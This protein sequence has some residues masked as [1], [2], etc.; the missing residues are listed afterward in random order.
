MR[1]RH[2]RRAE[3]VCFSLDFACFEPEKGENGMVPVKLQL[4]DVVVAGLMDFDQFV[5]FPVKNAEEVAIATRWDF[6][7]E[8][9]PDLGE[10]LHLTKVEVDDKS[11]IEIY[12]RWDSLRQLGIFHASC[13]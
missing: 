12:F 5:E 8:R 3:G 10:D 1:E 4:D 11:A 7:W 9:H 13:L 2:D 6:K